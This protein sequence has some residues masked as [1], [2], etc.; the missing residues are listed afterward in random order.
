MGSGHH[1]VYGRLQDFVTGE[2][3]TDTDDE[4][5]RQKLARF[6]VDQKGYLIADLRV[7]VHHDVSCG[8]LEGYSVTDLAVAP[9][10]KVLMIL[11]YGP[12]SLVTRER[13]ALAAARTLEAGF[14]VPLAVVSNGNEAEVLDVRTGNV[15][16]YGLENIP[17][18][19]ALLERTDS[20]DCSSVSARQLEA[21]KR[22]LM[23]YDGIEH[24][25]TCTEDWCRPAKT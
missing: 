4:R 6:L 18:R 2:W 3:L 5:L 10:G 20:F 16:D 7:R 23:A 19:K 21:E 12:G 17:D 8:D 1:Y 15:I 14:C 24:S 22:I 25:C 9:A 13:P 11:R